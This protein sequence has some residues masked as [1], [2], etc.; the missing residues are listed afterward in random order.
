MNPARRALG[1]AS[2]ALCAVM[3]QVSVSPAAALSEPPA[4]VL[5]GGSAAVEELGA[6]LPSVA[7]SYGMSARELEHE[8]LEDDELKLDESNKLV[9]QDSDLTHTPQTKAQLA[10]AT[11]SASW[12]YGGIDYTASDA[13]A[14]SSRP[15]A[16]VTI[17][18]D[19]NGHT[20]TNTYW[21]NTYGSSIVSR[22]LDLDGNASSFSSSERT[23]IG[24]T[25][26]AVAEDFAPWDV[27]VTTQE[28]VLSDLIKT[29]ASDT[30]FGIRVVITP[31]AFI[32]AGGVAYLNS[33]T[34]NSDTPAFCFGYNYGANNMALVISHEVGHT[35]N[36]NHDGTSTQGY[37][38]GHGSWGPIMGAPYGKATTQWSKGEYTGANNKEDDLAK[39]A[40]ITPLA[41]D[42]YADSMA[43]ALTLQSTSTQGR[44]STSADKDWFKFSLAS[45]DLGVT[46]QPSYIANL[47][48][49]VQLW[50]NGSLVATASGA[51]AVSS[52]FTSLTPGEYHLMVDGEG[53]GTAASTGYSDYGSVGDYLLTL[54]GDVSVDPPAQITVVPSASQ[55]LAGTSVSFTV[56]SST[57]PDLAGI[58]LAWSFSQG[59]SGTG[60]GVSVTMPA[61]TL[62]ATVTATTA[63]R[64]VTVASAQ[65]RLSKAPSVS[66]AVSPASAYAG[67]NVVF[68]ATAT[69]PDA[70]ALSYAWSFSDGTT[71]TGA[72][73]TKTMREVGTLTGTV[74]VTDADGNTAT[75][76][77]S[78]NFVTNLPPT[79]TV[80]ASKTTAPA[81]ALITFTALGTDPERTTVSY[82]WTFPD[83][84]T[85][86]SARVTKT[87]TDVGTNTASVKVTDAAGFFTTSSVSV[88]VTS[89]TAPVVTSATV[90]K[91]SAP[92][93]AKLSFGTVASDPD[94]QTLTY[95]WSF[96]DGQTGTGA[97][98]TKTFS[99]AGSYTATVTAT[100]PG[101]LSASKSVSFTVTPNRAPTV[102]IKSVAATTQVAP[103][104]FS[105]AAI[106]VDADNQAL[107]YSWSLSDGTSATTA[108]LAK[109][110]ST[111]GTLT[112]TVTVTDPGGL[113]ATSTVT[114]TVTPNTAPVVSTVAVSAS[115]AASG[116]SR[117]FS[118][119]ASDPDSQVLTYKWVFGDGSTSTS[120][121][122]TKTFST[123]GT[124]TATLTVTDTGG[125]TS[126]K[127]L[128]YVVS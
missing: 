39:I 93:P 59:S 3:A 21:N 82:L 40:S 6:S 78:A 106:G 116:T 98:L 76:S 45:G 111:A 109:K 118:S 49:T 123:K 9:Y 75:S 24:Q 101:G 16:P 63:S 124:Y 64:A 97:S 48:P 56:T 99:Q 128:S 105:V 95:A 112:A 110:L 100:D 20:T 18:L 77:K 115:S 65:V 84:S 117:V 58:S 41:P 52:T 15:T 85:S 8:L 57:H 44:I 34:W 81:P 80:T 73:A 19:F 26:A 122:V 62:T 68:S 51:G 13:F 35:F 127:S 88:T 126:S 72:T 67:T 36:L 23:T 46:V 17:Y 70:Q 54:S 50:K 125:L 104:S 33:I 12:S 7:R 113:T 120:A 60:T 108:T 53:F 22:G 11:A 74:T 28:P 102:T 79:V 69:D 5:L 32:S 96:S 27:N 29:D 31:D 14:L 86:T 89:N 121:S 2:L 30:R 71:A 42:D 83:G 87:L 43:D 107:T 94:K 37:Y 47:D 92:A 55:A 91:T 103:A 66:A 1:A 10:A 4:P 114:L 25:W 119:T 38:S 61:S 90:S